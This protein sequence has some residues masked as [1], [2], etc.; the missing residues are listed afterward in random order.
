MLRPLTTGE[1]LDRTFTLYRKNF[2]LFATIAA[3]PLLLLL[4][5]RTALLFLPRLTGSS[6]ESGQGVVVLTTIGLVGWTAYFCAAG[7]AQGA[8]VVAVSSVYLGKPTRAADCYRRLQGRFLR[9]MGIVIGV[10]V[11]TILASLLLLVPGIVLAIFWSLAIPIAVLEDA[12][13]SVAVSRSSDLTEGRRWQILLI[14]FIV[15]V[16][17]WLVSVIVSLPTA[18]F[19]FYYALHQMR[20]PLWLSGL[21]LVTTFLAELVIVPIW[22]V[23][24]SLVYYDARVRKEALDLELVMEQASG[25]PATAAVAAPTM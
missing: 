2:V 17:G 19:V 1:L 24:F 11:L 16:V 6:F 23:A 13:F 4:V 10:S 7:V 8:T 14:M 21:N 9:M 18:G 5:V 20:P 15:V 25:G 12:S 22:V 3:I